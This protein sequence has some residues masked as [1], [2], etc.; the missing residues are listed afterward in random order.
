LCQEHR[1][2]YISRV[3]KNIQNQSWGNKWT[4]QDQQEDGAKKNLWRMDI[5]Q[6]NEGLN[7]EAQVAVAQTGR[8]HS[9]PP[10]YSPL[11]PVN[12]PLSWHPILPHHARSVSQSVSPQQ[13]SSSPYIPPPKPISENTDLEI[14]SMDDPRKK[15]TLHKTN[16]YI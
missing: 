14:D 11:P 6:N 5:D 13:V 15:H 10:F 16:P 12:L 3:C 7:W 2:M 4:Q 8:C 9:K 1:A